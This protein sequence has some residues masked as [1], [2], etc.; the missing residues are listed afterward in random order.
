MTIVKQPGVVRTAYEV[1]AREW[2]SEIV[3]SVGVY[4]LYIDARREANL[5]RAAG[6]VV[7]IRPVI[8]RRR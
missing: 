8:V 4:D 1:V 3:E 5:W 7:E 6:L 2:E